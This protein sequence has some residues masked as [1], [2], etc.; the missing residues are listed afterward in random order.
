MKKMFCTVACFLLAMSVNAK[1]TGKKPPMS[2]K[3]LFVDNGLQVLTENNPEYECIYF[4]S[5][6]DADGKYVAGRGEK[7]Y[8]YSAEDCL[9]S[10]EIS[11]HQMEQLYPNYSVKHNL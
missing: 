3:K 6:W 7:F 2:L 5:V 8:S 1:D 10:A 4:V 9:E 11:V